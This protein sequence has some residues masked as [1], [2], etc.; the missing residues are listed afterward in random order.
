MTDEDIRKHAKRRLKAKADFKVFLGVW[1]AV[2]VLVTAI[3]F[4]SGAGAPFWPVWPIL[5]MGIAA[6]FMGLDAYG[7][8]RKF[9]TEADID[10]EV[11]RMRG[12][13]EA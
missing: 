5:G 11:R 7:P 1:A 13:P 9:I 4:A 2:S 10:A 3:W 6:L 8:G 12:G